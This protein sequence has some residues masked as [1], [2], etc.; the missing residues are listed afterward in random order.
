MLPMT[1]TEL[2]TLDSDGLPAR[3]TGQ[4]VHGKKYYFCRY[5]DIMTHGVGR[6][7]QGKLAYV[8]LFSG[9]GGSIVRG[10]QEEVD[11][12]PVLA[13][14][15]EFAR[16]IFVDIPE[17]LSCLKKRLA[18]HPKFSQIVFIE[19]DCNEVIEEVRFA[20]P[21]DHLMLAFIDPTGLQIRFRTIQRLVQNRSV[22]LLM[23]LQFGMGIRLN[24]NQY[25]K[26]EGAKLTA[27]LGN[28][29]WRKDASK[30]GSASQV[31][32]RIKN[33]YLHHLQEL[34]YLPVRDREIDIRNDQNVLLYF[35]AFAS[36]HPLGGKFWRE[37][38]K[39]DWT[40][41]RQMNYQRQD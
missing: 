35:I 32:R 22:D 4:W 19:G 17:V 15:Y 23:T 24:L 16:Y 11:G 2:V 28:A 1:Q 3:L 7:W 37:A 36:R 8:D 40:G 20:S 27:F 5:L 6:K 39:I 41:Q 13:L 12:S 33:R 38:I 9:P 30:G 29:E 18:G 31:L 25:I 21:A 10:S 26:A 14:N 34:G